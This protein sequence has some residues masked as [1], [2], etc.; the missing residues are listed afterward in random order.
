MLT[1][2][3]SEALLFAVQAHD[4]QTRKGT[5]IPYV[6][7][8]LAVA[9]LVLEHGG[10]EDCAI[11]GLLHDVIEDQEVHPSVIRNRFG[12]RVAQIVVEC[13]EPFRLQKVEDQQVQEPYYRDRKR[14]YLD[15]VQGGCPEA[16]LVAGCDKLHNLRCLLA[17]YRQHGEELWERFSSE[18]KNVLWYYEKIARVMGKGG[19][20]VA[21]EITRTSRELFRLVRGE[22]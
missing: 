14:A 4:G 16:H 20:P 19:S 7:H 9:A 5:D 11:A 10:D 3:F 13:T 22:D 18:K 2:R 15:Q 1:D 8:P 12:E 6:S 21:Q 17:D